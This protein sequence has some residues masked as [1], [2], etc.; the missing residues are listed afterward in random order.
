MMQTVRTRGTLTSPAALKPGEPIEFT[1]S[2]PGKKRD[3]LTLD[4]QRF[5]FENFNRNP[6]ALWMHGR[7]PARGAVPVGRW[8]NV[9]VRGTGPDATL[10]GELVFDQ[11]DEFAR[12]IENKFHREFLNA[13][14][15]MWGT[16]RNPNGETTYDLMEAGPVAIPADPDA[17]IAAGRT[18]LPELAR[19]FH[20][21]M[22][23]LQRAL[24]HAGEP[25]RVITPD[26][27]RDALLG[28][29][30]V[31]L[32]RA[33]G[34]LDHDDLRAQ[35]QRAVNDRYGTQETPWG[36]M[37]RAGIFAV[38]DEHVVV[39]AFEEARFVRHAYA[40]T[41]DGDATIEDGERVFLAFNPA[42]P[43]E[44]D[45][46]RARAALTTALTAL[47]RKA[48]PHRAASIIRDALKPH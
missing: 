43:P 14:S 44:T 36:E 5:R 21:G 39:R 1:L 46:E 37:A 11:D 41:N 27:V 25:H 2:A 34:P 13:V 30:P 32:S 40:I 22:N 15:I 3:G 33:S 20:H 42:E 24:D 31:L 28:V 47:T 4:V 9:G 17:L 16:E 35:L 45:A 7:D 12:M 29:A 38:F 6:V 23:A 19:E 26:D 48:A 8:L 18:A 10:A